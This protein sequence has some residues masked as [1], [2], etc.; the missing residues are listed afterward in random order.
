[1][2]EVGP[3]ARMLVAKPEAFT[4]LLAAGVK[5]GV[6]ARHAARAVETLTL[7]RQIYRWLDELTELVAAGRCK[8]HDT[9]SWEVPAEAKGVGLTE[10]PRGA[11]GHWIS[12]KGQKIENYQLVVP[13]TWNLGP[14]DDRGVRGPVEEALIG[15]PVPDVRNPLNVVRIVRSFD[16]CI[17]CAVHIIEPDSNRILEFRIGVVL[18]NL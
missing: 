4:R 11:L 7:T 2:M 14:R 5:P 1:A 16:P 10:A 12:I 18:N 6:V 13:S 17:S 8:I 15:C 9:A 3:L